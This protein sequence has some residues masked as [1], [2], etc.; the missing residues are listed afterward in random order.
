ME[1]YEIRVRGRVSP[2]T[3]RRIIVVLLV[4]SIANLLWRT[5]RV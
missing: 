5:V 4:A 2:V 1:E 3:F